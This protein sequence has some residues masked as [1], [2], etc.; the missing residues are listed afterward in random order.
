MA[1]NLHLTHGI[2][3]AGISWF[4]SISSCLIDLSRGI[5][6]QLCNPPLHTPAKT[7]QL[8]SKENTAQYCDH[9]SR[10]GYICEP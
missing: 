4:S 6:T 3:H 2:K 8:I 7:L 5:W 1:N 9:L 10:N